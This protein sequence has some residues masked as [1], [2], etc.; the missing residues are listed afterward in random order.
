LE[1]AN[2]LIKNIVIKKGKI[3]DLKI[4]IKEI[5]KDKE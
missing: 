5:K 3:K 2:R 4:K 1:K